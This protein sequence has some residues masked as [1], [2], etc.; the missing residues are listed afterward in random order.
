MQRTRKLLLPAIAVA[1]LMTLAACGGSD[2][3]TSPST[4]GTTSAPAT[5][6]GTVATDR[7]APEL[8]NLSSLKAL[9]ISYNNFSGEI[10]SELGRLSHAE[11]LLLGGN[12]T[13]CVP[14]ELL[15]IEYSDFANL[16]LPC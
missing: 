8:G 12:L 2:A 6:A 13:G 7:A 3:P 9:D 15:E 14:R 10:P 5:D 1:L 16:S 11:T 4:S